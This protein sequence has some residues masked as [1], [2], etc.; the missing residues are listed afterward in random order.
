[1]TQATRETVQVDPGGIRGGVVVAVALASVLVMALGVLMYL[2]TLL[3]VL[4]P[5]M[6]ADAVLLIQLGS[7]FEVLVLAFGLADSLNQSKAQA[8]QAER[9][10]RVTQQTLAQRLEEQVHDRTR[11][12]ERANA[13]LR[14]QAITDELTGAFNRRHFNMVLEARA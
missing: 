12:L 8:L 13:R 2:L 6:S 5:S 9:E 1:M 14:E 11:E 7:A 10:A 4:P 3:P